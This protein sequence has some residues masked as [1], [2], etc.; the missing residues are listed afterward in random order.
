MHTHKHMAASPP[1]STPDHI[2]G[3]RGGG[4]GGGE[5]DDDLVH[6]RDSNTTTNGDDDGHA[7]NGP[8]KRRRIPVACS[9]CRA[10]KSRCDGQRPKCGSCEAQDIECIYAQNPPTANATVP[11][12]FLDLVEARLSAVERDLRVLK[13]KNSQTGLLTPAHMPFRDEN[14]QSPTAQT[15][16]GIEV[17]V[18]ADDDDDASSVYSPD[19]TDGIGSIEFAAEED[20][21]AY[22]G[23]TSNIAFTRVI[24]RAISTVIKDPQRTGP[25][26][27]CPDDDLQKHRPPLAVSRPPSPPSH[28]RKVS[29]TGRRS[30]PETFHI[31]PEEE[32][33]RLIRRYFSDTGLL[34]PYIHE[35][36]FWKTYLSARACRFRGVKKS[37]LGL[38]NMVMAMAM[39]TDMDA[40]MNAAERA[41]HGDVFLGRA[42]AL[43]VGQMMTSASVETVQVMLLMTQYLQS[44]QRSIRTWTVHGLAVK[45]ALQLGLHSE[46]ALR[47]HA[48]L[49]RE[50][51][52]RTWYACI[53]LDRTLC[54]TFGRPPAIPESYVR[55]PLPAHYMEFSS[56]NKAVPCSWSTE[57]VSTAFFNVTISLHQ[58]MCKV[59]DMLYAHNI[60][61]STPTPLADT[62]S[63]I[64]QTEQQLVSWRSSLPASLKLVNADELAADSG[65]LSLQKKL[66][67]IL[68][69]RYHNLRILA[70]RPILDR[71]LEL[72]QGSVLDPHE[73]SVLWQ[74]S[75]RSKSSCFQSAEVIVNVVSTTTH[76]SAE[77]RNLLGAWWFT[78]YYTFNAALTL[79]AI[80]IS[81]DVNPL[82]LDNQMPLPRNGSASVTHKQKTVL[83]Q[84][85]ECL[86]LIDHR[87]PVI[88]KCTKFTSALRHC[89][90]GFPRPRQLHHNN[91]LQISA[92]TLPA[93]SRRHSMFEV[94]PST[95]TMN[96]SGGMAIG[97]HHM[98]AGLSIPASA[99][100]LPPPA[101][102]ASFLPPEFDFSDMSLDL[103]DMMG[104]TEPGF[105]DNMPTSDLVW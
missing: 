75:H 104:Y 43:C 13:G 70:H 26:S 4:G 22:F 91:M 100:M 57:E 95:S 39:S 53:I 73:A 1:N 67:V 96:S 99:A 103:T 58:I 84:A 81:E 68:T 87:N 94:P 51:R 78:L 61:C 45:A 24:R 80:M 38:L 54:M 63:V 5:D 12:V 30:S 62:A 98:P 40:G 14:N 36:T 50:T 16:P 74:I 72:L 6:R 77:H 10:R 48:P 25:L 47:R 42:K 60:G 33:T 83:N 66:R 31:P 56:Q 92:Q 64:L 32:T 44:T 3:L 69:L 29:W 23:P 8:R 65:V 17:S 79:V 105:I 21:A 93:G 52:I 28:A 49:E 89:A 76:S 86:P 101:G 59:I 46:E 35:E 55:T 90:Q 37:W 9:W 41:V 2:N 71:Y 18:A 88:E 7:E 102:A 82:D 11:K 27:P 97:N 34:F 19:V 20:S 15:G 85:I